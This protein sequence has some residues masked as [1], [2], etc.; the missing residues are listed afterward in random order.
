M[1]PKTIT[2]IG[3]AIYV[4]SA[5]AFT[6]EL[7]GEITGFYLLNFGWIVHEMVELVGCCYGTATVPFTRATPKWKNCCAPPRV[8]LPPCYKPCLRSGR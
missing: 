8:N 7:I 4:L 6:E 2:K 3:I 1:K 5:L